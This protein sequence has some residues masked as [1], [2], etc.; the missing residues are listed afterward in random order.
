MQW[1]N[2]G[3]IQK[4]ETTTLGTRRRKKN[5]LSLVGKDTMALRKTSPKKR[6]KGNPKLDRVLKSKTNKD[7]KNRWA[8]LGLTLTLSEEE[9]RER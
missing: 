5:T 6:T 9:N 8:S 2:W 3:K 1:K 4:Q 7:E